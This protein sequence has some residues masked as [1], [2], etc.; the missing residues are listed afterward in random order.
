MLLQVRGKRKRERGREREGAR[1][2]RQ[3]ERRA[4]K[5]WKEIKNKSINSFLNQN[6]ENFLC[7]CERGRVGVFM[8]CSVSGP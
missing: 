4:G 8:R 2:E 3:A 7:H 1:G 6:D 5:E